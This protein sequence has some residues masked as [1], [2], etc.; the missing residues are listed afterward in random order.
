MHKNCTLPFRTK[1]HY[2]VAFTSGTFSEDFV[3]PGWKIFFLAHQVS[4]EVIAALLNGH[5]LYLRKDFFVCVRV[6]GC[7]AVPVR[8]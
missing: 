2:P 7:A 8:S 3:T 4:A 5:I 1:P 6:G